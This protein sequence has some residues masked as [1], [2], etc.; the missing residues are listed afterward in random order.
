MD[1]QKRVKL[2]D[3]IGQ[4]GES[5]IFYSAALR[6]G[7]VEI[8]LLATFGH[9]LVGIGLNIVGAGSKNTKKVRV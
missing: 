1:E 4:A 3:A 2:A 9:I 6:R 7:D 5:M 8:G